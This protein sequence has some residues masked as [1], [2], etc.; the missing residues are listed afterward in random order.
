MTHEPADCPVER[1][2][3]SSHYTSLHDTTLLKVRNDGSLWSRTSLPDRSKIADA[4]SLKAMLVATNIPQ[5]KIP[6]HGTLTKWLN[7]TDNT[8]LRLND[9]T[10]IKSYWAKNTKGNFKTPFGV[11]AKRGKDGRIKEAKIITEKFE[12]LELWE[13]VVPDG[14]KKGQ[15]IYQKRLVPLNSALRSLMQLP[16]ITWRGKAPAEFQK[17]SQTVRKRSSPSANLFLDRFFPIQRK[18]TSSK[19]VRP[20]ESDSRNREKVLQEVRS[21][22]GTAGIAY[23]R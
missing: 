7:A 17:H 8:V 20:I 16:G 6:P 1:H 22:T 23:L 14:N 11:S 5:D 19:R 10:P 18:G 13:G 15:S 12:A 2:R 21:P 9:G 3:S 4:E